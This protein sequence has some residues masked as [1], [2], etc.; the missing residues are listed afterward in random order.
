MIHYPIV[1]SNVTKRPTKKYMSYCDQFQSYKFSSE[2]C[3]F[4]NLLTVWIFYHKHTPSSKFIDA[5][6]QSSKRKKSSTRPSSIKKKKKLLQAARF[7]NMDLFQVLSLNSSRSDI[8]CNCKIHSHT[9]RKQS[10]PVQY[11]SNLSV[12]T[13]NPP[14]TT[15]QRA[16]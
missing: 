7:R 1:E 8:Q 13:P 9:L 4:Q 11:S 6:I 15:N 16:Q 2:K 5:N 14:L 3:S 12:L 10:K